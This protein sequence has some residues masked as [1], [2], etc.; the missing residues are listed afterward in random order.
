MMLSFATH[1]LISIDPEIR[2]GRPCIIGTRISVAD[3][4]A[5]L[6]NGMGFAEIIS[7]FPE[8]DE[9]MIRACCRY[10]ANR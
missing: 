9:D 5:W 6:G 7:D 2:F 3:V 1:P 10:A 8:L 4:L